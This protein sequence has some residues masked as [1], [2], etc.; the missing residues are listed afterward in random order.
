VADAA[1]WYLALTLIG[2]GGVLPAML[3]FGPLRSGGVLYARPLALVLVAEGA[4]LASALGHV[5]YGLPLVLVMV[6]ALW[7]WSG[8]LVWRRPALWG[9]AR[10]R[11]RLL[12]AGEMV[13]ALL[14]ALIV[15]VRVQAPNAHYTEK[16]MDL[17]LIT[18]VRAADT[19]PPLDLWFAGQPLAYYHLGAVMVD[20]V[21]RITGQAPAIEF[22]LALASTGAMAGAAAFALGGDIVALSRVRRRATPWIAGVLA[23]TLL[24]FAAPLEGLLELLAPRGI[25]SDALWARLGIEGFPGPADLEGGVP[26]QFWWWWRATRVLPGMISEFPAFS[27]V[28][29]DLHAHLL[30]LPLK[31]LALA[32]VLPTLAPRTGLTIQ[33]WVFRPGALVVAAALFAGLAMTHTWD[34][35]IFVGL[36]LGAAA[37]AFLAVG[38]P[39]PATLIPAVRFLTMPLAAAALLAW[40]LLSTTRSAVTG[41]APV[42]GPASDPARLLLIWLPLLLPVAT[43]AWL[44]RTRASRAALVAGLALAGTGVLAWVAFALGSGQGAALRERGVGWITLVLLVAGCGSAAAAAVS[45]LRERDTAR[46]AWLALAAAAA[47][48][49]LTTELVYLVDAFA[50]RINTVFKFWYAV[51]LLLAIAGAAALAMVYDRGALLRP[52]IVTVPMLVLALVATAGPLLYAPAAAV[53]RAREG[54]PRTLDALAYLDSFDPGEA[55]TLRWL[56]THR[57][58]LGPHPVLL[59]AVSSTYTDGNFISAASGVPTL[60]GWWPHQLV[61]R[62]PASS[63][64]ARRTTVQQIFATA[65]RADVARVAHEAGVTQIYLGRQEALQYGPDLAARF[66]GWAVLFE[67]GDSRILAVPAARGTSP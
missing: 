55:A 27:I 59:E 42:T 41:V 9:E 3:L 33:W 19:M 18:S 2:G 65:D 48:I 15:V 34:A 58:E 36:W 67:A 51:W 7:A 39:L 38:W 25:G 10:A 49:I 54:E 57:T 4:W 50:S 13:C 53:A 26:T 62:G 21:G 63:L 46:S 60:L 52:R 40:P 6:A 11:W 1:R 35:A 8:A 23:V 17:M 45:A 5:P 66:A 32:A 12:A 24:L 29:G 64:E 61:W 37:A 47:A 31:V 16:P 44:L 22:N 56:D 14:F 28:L 30:A 43:G 20:V